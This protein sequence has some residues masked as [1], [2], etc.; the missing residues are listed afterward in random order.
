KVDPERDGIDVHEQE[1]AAELSFQP[2]VHSASVT[3]AIVAAIADEDLGRHS[4]CL[5]S[6]R[7]LTASLLQV[8]EPRQSGRSA[9][10]CR[11]AAECSQQSPPS[12]GDC[13]T[14]LPRE[15]RKWND[16]TPRACCP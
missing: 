11:R 2:I 8:E 1:V 5:S 4:A 3:R 10:R 6:R 15:V 13:H 16:T 14:L 12:D 7:N 9:T